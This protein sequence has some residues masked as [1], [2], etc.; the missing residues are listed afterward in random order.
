MYYQNDNYGIKVRRN[1]GEHFNYENS[2]WAILSVEG[3]DFTQV[4]I[5]KEPRGLGHG[6]IITGKRKLSREIKIQVAARNLDSVSE[7]RQNLIGFHNSNY[8]YDVAITY[9]GVTMVARDCEISA[10]SYPTERISK[11]PI[12]EV[13]Y[14]SPYADLFAQ[15]SDVTGFFAINPMWHDT[16]VYA[17]GKKLAFG[18]IKKT[19]SK[20]INYLGSEVAPIIV[21]VQATGYVP[22]IDIAIE[23]K[24][25]RIK[26]IL[27]KGD[28]LVIDCEKRMVLKNDIP[29]DP[30]DYDAWE[31][32]EMVLEYGDN[33]VKISKNDNI[34]FT[35]EISYTGRYGGL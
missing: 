29:V 14:L 5:F 13:F 33:L 31:L 12:L 7:L 19:T 27:N 18:E 9:H 11:N 6:D 4:E 28:T 30:K 25:A 8:T 17:N 22:G 23:G 16:R 10:I 21:R 26:T 3:A 15:S 24:R 35:A 34:A 20:V 1:D 2:D 32:F